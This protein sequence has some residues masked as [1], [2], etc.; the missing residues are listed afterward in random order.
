VPGVYLASF[1]AEPAREWAK[2]VARFRRID[3]LQERVK[4]LEQK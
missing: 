3:A 1:P 2:Q 4:K